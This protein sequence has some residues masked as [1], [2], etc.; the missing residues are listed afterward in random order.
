[1][2]ADQALATGSSR[3]LRILSKPFRETEL[4]SALGAARHPKPA[5]PS[6]VIRLSR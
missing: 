4:L 6:N 2:I 3:G 1:M 5:S